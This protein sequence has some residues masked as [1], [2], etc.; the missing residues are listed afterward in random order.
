M[1]GCWWDGRCCR[2]DCYGCAAAGIVVVAALVGALTESSLSHRLKSTIYGPWSQ[3]R[4]KK[5][6]SRAARLGGAQISAAVLAPVRA[7]L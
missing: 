2:S 4:L 6:K 3:G 5:K 1:L 7:Q